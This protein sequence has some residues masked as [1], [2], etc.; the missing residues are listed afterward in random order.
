MLVL[1]NMATPMD[2]ALL[3]LSFKTKRTE[4][5]NRLKNITNYVNK[6]STKT[7]YFR[8]IRSSTL[9]AKH[10]DGMSINKH[11][12]KYFQQCWSYVFLR[13]Y[14]KTLSVNDVAIVKLD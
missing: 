8:A 4:C 2:T 14:I 13:N 7:N 3:L 10:I 1:V 11:T 5:F 6:N 9:I 12:K